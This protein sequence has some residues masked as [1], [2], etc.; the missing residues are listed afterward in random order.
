MAGVSKIVFKTVRILKL[1]DLEYPTTGSV[2]R[3]TSF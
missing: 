3:H 1:S 2:R